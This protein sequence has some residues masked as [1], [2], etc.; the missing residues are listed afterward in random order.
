MP[1]IQLRGVT[2]V[3]GGG[4]RTVTAL[5]GVDL[6][7]R[8][9]ELVAIE[10][11]SGSGKSTLLNTIALL[12]AP[13]GGEYLLGGR[14]VD[15]LA[16]DERAALRSRCFAFVFQSFHLLERRPVVDSVEL[17]MFYRG[18]P[19]RARRAR[20]LA[21]LEQVGL[22]DRAFQ[23]AHLLSGGERQRVAIARAL[24]VGAPVV[25]ADEPT[26][27]L[28]SANSAVVVEALR[29][30]AAQGRTVV[31]VTHDPVVASV[32]TRRIQ[33]SDGSIVSD[34]RAVA[35]TVPDSDRRTEVVAPGRD[36]RVRPADVLRDAAASLLARPGRSAGL[37]GA[38]GVA[39]ALAVATL[40]I[41]ATASAQVSDRFD[42]TLNTQVTLSEPPGLPV[43]PFAPP[44]AEGV[45]AALA[46]LAGATAAGTLLTYGDAV[47][48][49]SAVH[50]RR[51]TTVFGGTSGL[52]DAGR[53]DVRWA[54][55]AQ[56]EPTGG[57]V[58]LGQVAADELGI[59]PLVLDPTVTIDGRLFAVAGVITQADRAI[60][61][62]SGVLVAEADA[63]WFGE[64]QGAQRLILTR[65]GAAPS[66]AA[67]APL[68]LRPT[69]PG[70]VAVDSPVD[71]DRLRAGIQD[72][73]R[74]VLL[75]LT[76]VAGLA[77]AAALTNSMVM[78]VVERARELGLRRA[79]G[80]R[81]RHVVAGVLAEST[82]IGVLGGAAGFVLGVGAVLAMTIANRWIPV[83][84]LAIAPLSVAAG[85]VIASLGGV[86]AA[87]RAARIQ[88]ADAL[89][90]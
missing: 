19:R 47:V 10:G 69:D 1:L 25:V 13:S 33:M 20:A 74:L 21:A 65:P 53:I 50:P 71:P 14:R 16:E 29:A 39:V 6:V 36:S 28:D 44:T 70:A 15:D 83:L 61:L 77:S 3:F 63:S 2:Q 56:R 37:I 22:R 64:P 81:R 89:R 34:V 52:L 90:A 75:V 18:L 30:V 4:H 27:N 67:Q 40:G 31:L 59:G 51:G 45:D 43:D 82:T 35:A 23:G 80:A 9:G 86:V 84:D 17:G 11:T 32:G 88:P 26:G 78:S 57:R 87:W 68:A 49:A 62:L 55:P 73:L 41:S 76:A 8:Q 58:L 79:I 60:P 46:D 7:I 72:D 42:A 54:D 5:D 38:V 48:T 24:A 12:Q 66:V 85:A